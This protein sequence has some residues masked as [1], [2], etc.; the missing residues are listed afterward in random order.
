M[1]GYTLPASVLKALTLN[2]LRVYISG[3]DIFEIQSVKDGYDP[4]SVRNPSNK[5]RYPFCR[6]V[7]C[8]LELKF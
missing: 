6:T 3:G 8:G 7:T 4:E 1:L 2:S 5:S